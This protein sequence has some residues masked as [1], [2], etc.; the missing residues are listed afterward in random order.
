ME[1]VCSKLINRKMKKFYY[2]YEKQIQNP[3]KIY[4]DNLTIEKY[5]DTKLM[6]SSHLR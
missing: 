3:Y 6:V 2:N 4:Q 1:A 5:K